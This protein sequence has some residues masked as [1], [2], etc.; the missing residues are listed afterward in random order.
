V[1]QRTNPR[2]EKAFLREKRRVNAFSKNSYKRELARSP[3]PHTSKKKKPSSS[4]V[5]ARRRKM[6]QKGPPWGY[7]IPAVIVIAVI[8]GAVYFST[9]S[10]VDST[11]QTLPTGSYDFPIPCLGYEPLFLHIH[12][13]L[14]IFINNQK[15]VIP[16]AVGIQNPAIEGQTNGGYIYGAGT[17]SCFEP[18]HTHDNSGIIHIESATNTNYTLGQFF[19]IWSVS[20]QYALVG[21]SKQPI[22]FNSTDI[23]GYKD[24]ST[25]TLTLLVDGQPSDAYSSLVL[26]TLAYCNAT[27]SISTSS[28]CHATAEGDPEW[29]GAQGT[30]PYGTGHTIVIEYNSTS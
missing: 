19:D 13:W 4:D 10:S 25:G 23:L 15:V 17:N 1:A 30:Y 24:N 26:D 11:V 22:V 16:G 18:V 28:P 21:T 29:N 3:V 20:Y 9:R 27:N 14:Q 8:I 2:S 6:N 7:I 12:V 5:S